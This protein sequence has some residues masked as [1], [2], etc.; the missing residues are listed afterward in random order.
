M[1]NKYKN[2]T[3]HVVC[4]SEYLSITEPKT[5]TLYKKY[6]ILKLNDFII[7]IE[8][9]FRSETFNLYSPFGGNFCSEFYLRKEKLKKLKNKKWK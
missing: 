3:T 5:Y 1:R 8:N 9:D 4:I 7:T 2:L 6:K